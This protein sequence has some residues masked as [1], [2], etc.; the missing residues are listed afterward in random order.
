VGET[1]LSE[2]RTVELH[3]VRPTNDGHIVAAPLYYELKRAHAGASDAYLAPLARTDGALA[4][5]KC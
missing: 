5:E 3:A 1:C 4:F 2:V